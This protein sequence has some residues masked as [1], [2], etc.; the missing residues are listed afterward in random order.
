MILFLTDNITKINGMSIFSVHFKKWLEENYNEYIIILE[1]NT[2]TLIHVKQNSNLEYSLINKVF[3]NG[4]Y[5][6]SDIVVRKNH[7][8]KKL[9]Y[10]NFILDD[11]CTFTIISHGWQKVKNR[12]SIYNIAYNI[13]N[14]I[15]TL[16]IN[17]ISKH[18]NSI[19]FIS[20]KCDDYRHYDYK[21]SIKNN[22]RFEYID[23]T[24]EIFVNHSTSINA[25]LKNYILVISNFDTVKNL[26]LLFKINFY[27]KRKGKK[28]KNFVLLT[29]KPK[30]FTNKI[31][32]KLLVFS[33]VTI[34]FDQSQKKFLITNCN[35][36]FI[37]SHT[38]YLPI[39]AFEAFSMNKNVLSFY[40]IIGLSELKKYHFIKK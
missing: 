25:C 31:I 38:E 37:P 39:V 27:N 23:F 18:Y 9:L 5:S 16:N 22:F 4:H 30:S 7:L 33:K 1:I 20:N 24:K 34:I 35:Y 26:F 21:W 15:K 28:I 11:D 17:S 40:F 13:K 6:N 29:T 32:Y 12:F 8:R 14:L 36:L 10:Y 2:N 19:I 3:V